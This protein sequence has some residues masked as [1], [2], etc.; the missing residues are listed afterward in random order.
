MKRWWPKAS[1]RGVSICFFIE[2]DNRIEAIRIGTARPVR[3]VTRL[4]QL[5]CD[6]IE[7]IDPGFGI[8]IMRLAATLTE[9]LV[10]KQMISSLT[11]EPEAD[12]SH[13]IDTL[14]NR[15]GEQR[16]YRFAPVESDLPERS[17]Q[18]IAP[19]APDTGETWSELWPRPARLLEETELIEKRWPL[20]PDPPPAESLARCRRRVECRSGPEP[21]GFGDR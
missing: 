18:R 7:T 17:V 4:S 20:L 5:L 15:V 6:K 10:P 19:V 11:E 3:D 2:V 16:L 1:A 9:H 12:V 13:L 8:E 21:R 14:A